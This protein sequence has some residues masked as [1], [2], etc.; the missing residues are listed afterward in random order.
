M[1]NLVAREK[2]LE[3]LERLL[4]EELTENLRIVFITGEAGGG[5]TALV[6][7]FVKPIRE[8]HIPSDFFVANGK[9]YEV[10]GSLQEPYLPFVQILETILNENKGS[11]IWDHLRN[12]IA[13][14]APEWL[15][16]IP[17]PGS[18]VAAAAIRTIQWGQREFQDRGNKI[19]LSRRL[20]QYVN[21]L[22]H[23]SEKVSLILWI[24]DIH[25]ADNASLDMISFLADHAQDARILLI[26]TYRPSDVAHDIDDKPH[27]VRQLVNKL[28]RYNQCKLI[29]LSNFN[30]V[31]IQKYLI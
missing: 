5:K 30:L 29:N 19:D 27:P 23:V 1:I 10:A 26:A 13:E 17:I 22:R 20:V 4:K 28:K 6:E 14:L 25:W 12:G 3:Q 15:Q 24:D 16:A 8:E 18:E 9:C 2:Q 7:A 21:A 31:D 11:P